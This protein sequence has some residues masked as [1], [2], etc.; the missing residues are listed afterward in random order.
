MSNTVPFQRA[1]LSPEPLE[2]DRSNYLLGL[3]TKG[4]HKIAYVEWAPK[5]G[6]VPTLCLHG[7]T[8]QSRDFDFLAAELAMHGRWVVCPDLPGRGRSASL[9]DPDDYA[10]P[11]Y[12]ADMNALIA[13]LGASEVDWV[14]TSLGGL[15]G[16]VLA[17]MPGS[18]I[19]R[20]VV[21]DIGPFVSST[22]LMRIGGYL[23]D[24]PASF[25]TMEAAE[26]YFRSI[27]APYGDLDDPQWR[28]ITM[29]SVRWDDERNRFVM[30]CDG[31]IARGF[32]SAWF[33][34]LNIW[35]YWEQ[36]K[37]PTLILHGAK[38]DLLTPQL[39]DEMLARNPN[40]V[41][42]RFDECGH[43]PPLFEPH[44]IK[45]VTD[46]LMARRPTDTG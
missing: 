36:I 39:C 11:Q 37:V 32:R 29:H 44:Q 7:L 41:V 21:N 6:G 26:E 35:K 12:C 24:M 30:L 13:R 22:G 5:A 31:E 19:R 27:L 2:P 23:R 46:F 1:A 17:G 34:S 18:C 28:H 15:V 9:A 3:S 4:Y 40:A 16:M 43:V 38:S 42:H 10:L 45:V 25:A 14:G 20:L 33:A 8:R